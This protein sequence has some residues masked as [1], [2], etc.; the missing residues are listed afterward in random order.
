MAATQ[1]KLTEEQQIKMFGETVA[2]MEEAAE[3]LGPLIFNETMYAMQILS[4]AQEV[5]AC[6]HAELARQFINKA[7]FFLTKQL[8]KEA[9]ERE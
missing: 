9:Q 2:Q 4:D 3:M 5:L 1:T 8:K 6:G 7:K